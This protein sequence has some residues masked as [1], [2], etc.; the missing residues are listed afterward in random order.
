MLVAA[1]AARLEA[2]DLAL[3]TAVWQRA[4]NGLSWAEV[5][6][7]SSSEARRIAVIV[8]HIDP[9]RFDIRLDVR[10]RASGRAAPWTVD[11]AP[12]SAVLALNAGQFTSGGPWGWVVHGG[13]ERRAPRTGPLAPAIVVDTAGRVRMVP[14]DSIAAVRATRAIAEAFQSYPSL[15]TGHGELPA[16]L[17][18]TGRGVNLRHRDAR[19][20]IGTRADGTLLIALTRFDGF[21]TLLSRVPLG[22]TTPEMAAVMGALGCRQAVMLDGGISGQLLVRD[23]LGV[24]HA[25]RGLRR[26]PLGLIAIPKR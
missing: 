8:V 11:D 17:T 14:P 19:L 25:W 2:Q 20:A 6:L 9:S 16:A 21:G 1:I 23:T 24:T 4:G 15:L 12:D 3:G 10:R 22:L 26:V 18:D 13:V 7:A 5:P